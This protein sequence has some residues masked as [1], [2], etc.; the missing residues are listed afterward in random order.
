VHLIIDQGCQM[1]SGR[2][3]SLGGLNINTAYTGRSEG[4][5]ASSLV[6]RSSQVKKLKPE[7]H[8]GPSLRG[9]FAPGGS[10]AA[11]STRTLGLTFTHAARLIRTSDTWSR[12]RP[13]I[14]Q[15]VRKVHRR[16][17]P[18]GWL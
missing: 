6:R 18:N 1:V 11:I 3:R 16:Q 14:R 5:A 17:R 7:S 2:L 15:R 8:P 4:P 12:P 13:F 9:R 10:C